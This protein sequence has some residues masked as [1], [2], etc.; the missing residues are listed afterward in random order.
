MCPKLFL[1]CVLNLIYI[2]VGQVQE[3]TPCYTPNDEYGLCI[4][5]KKCDVLI[6]LLKTGSANE[7]VRHFLRSS[8]CGF[9]G[10]TPLVCCPPKPKTSRILGDGN[11][12]TSSENTSNGNQVTLPSF[13]DCGSSRK[14][15]T[16]VV[17]GMP[18]SL[19]AYPW[20]VALGYR[21]PDNAQNPKWLCG[22]TMITDKHILTAGHC[23]YNRNDLYIARVGEHDL[24]N[25]T[26]GASPEDIPLVKAKI[27]EDYSSVKYTNDIAI[28]TLSKKPDNDSVVP[29]CLPH[30]EPYR[31]NTF[32]RYQPFVAGWGALYFHGPSSNVLRVASIPV[33][34]NSACKRAYENQTIIDDRIL[35]AG[36]P[37][38]G[39]DAC[40]GDSGG[41][42]MYGKS[43]GE[44]DIT[45]YQ[46][47][48]VS[49]G[50]RC[51]EQGYPGVYTRVTNFID[52]IQRNLD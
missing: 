2:S 4:N 20:I 14:G 47:G 11:S 9:I 6:E 25:K 22:G 45:Y 21:N 28:L 15:N 35:C 26:D 51:A 10:T 49:Y 1:F 13:P 23:V 50:F 34:D 43:A 5:I 52:W 40:Q 30:S 33:V 46:I 39:K 37:Q 32:L 17:G 48:V 19:G 16:R 41:P 27:H 29:I 24:Y 7:T 18:A 3:D 8:T 44:V 42:L 12:A 36:W 38:G 31:S